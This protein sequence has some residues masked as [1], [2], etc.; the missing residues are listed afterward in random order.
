MTDLNVKLGTLP[1][2][3]RVD[4]KQ[5][6]QRTEWAQPRIDL[7]G[8]NLFAGQ[9]EGVNQKLGVGSKIYY[10]AQAGVDRTGRTL[11]FC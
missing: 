9:Y 5:P 2:A 7:S 11:D 6:V 3:T 8:N 4:G 10:P 1:I